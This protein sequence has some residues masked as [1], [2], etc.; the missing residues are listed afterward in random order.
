MAAQSCDICVLVA[1]S[2]LS[3]GER[4]VDILGHRRRYAPLFD[5]LSLVLR[6]VVLYTQIDNHIRV[7]NPFFYSKN[8]MARPTSEQGN[9][10]RR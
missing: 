5:V 2:A 10:R 3:R 6:I 8:K 1:T 7:N 4:I 9:E